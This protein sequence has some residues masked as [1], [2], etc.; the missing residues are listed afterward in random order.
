M[1][2]LGRLRRQAMDDEIFGRAA[3]LETLAE[4]DLDAADAGD[5]LDADEFGFALLQGL[6]RAVPLARNLFQMPPQLFR[7]QGLGTAVVRSVRAAHLRLAI[8]R[9]N[10]HA[11]LKPLATRHSRSC[12]REALPPVSG[13]GRAS[14]RPQG[15]AGL[16]LLPV[17]SFR[18][19]GTKGTAGSLRRRVVNLFCAGAMS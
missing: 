3:V 16:N 8:C 14:I 4:I 10:P 5:A 18:L 11:G 9:T 15:R 19:G 12:Q 17:K 1:G 7:G 13:C 2:F 6:V